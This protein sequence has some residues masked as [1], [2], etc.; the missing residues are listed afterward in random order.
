M[1]IAAGFTHTKEAL[2]LNMPQDRYLAAIN[3]A[4]W[5]NTITT[6]EYRHDENYGLMT[7]ATGAGMPVTPVPGSLGKSA[8]MITAQFGAYF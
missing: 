4:F 1:S 7:T 3:A 8:D 2:A 5:H 6:L